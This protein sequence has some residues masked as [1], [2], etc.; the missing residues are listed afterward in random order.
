M[1]DKL[2]YP[3]NIDDL[4]TKLEYLKKV[5][6]NDEKKTEYLNL[7]KI[8]FDENKICEKITI[9]LDEGM[10]LKPYYEIPNKYGIQVWKKEKE[11]NKIVYNLISNYEDEFTIP[12]E[13]IL[14]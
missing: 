2:I 4:L 10:F 11:Y 6:I 14:I 7:W 12:G 3:V 8:W 1:E 9:D 13:S 5:Y